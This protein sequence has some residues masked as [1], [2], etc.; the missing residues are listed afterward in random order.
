LLW[1]ARKPPWEAIAWIGVTFSSTI[2]FWLTGGVGKAAA[3]GSGK[4]RGEVA[5]NRG[6]GSLP[7]ALNLSFDPDLDPVGPDREVD[8][9]WVC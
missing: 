6:D 8:V 9:D 4:G 3:G 2:F 7:G 1:L 5:C